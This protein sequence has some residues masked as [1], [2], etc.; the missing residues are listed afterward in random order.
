MQ[1]GDASSREEHSFSFREE[2]SF[3]SSD[4][5]GFCAPVDFGFWGASLTSRRSATRSPPFHHSR[6]DSDPIG[7]PIARSGQH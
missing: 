2:H 4:E 7:L 5:K 3:P 1:F 6:S